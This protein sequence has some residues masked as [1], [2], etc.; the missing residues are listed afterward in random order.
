MLAWA[1]R[2]SAYVEVGLLDILEEDGD[3]MLAG[4]AVVDVAGAVGGQIGLAILILGDFVFA[5]RRGS[6]AGSG[7][8]SSEQRAAHVPLIKPHGILHKKERLL[9]QKRRAQGGGEVEM[10]Q[11]HS[12][13]SDHL[14]GI[15]MQFAGHD[16]DCGLAQMPALHSPT[17]AGCYWLAASVIAGWLA[18][19]LAGWALARRQAAQDELAS[20]TLSRLVASHSRSHFTC[21]HT[22]TKRLYLDTTC[23]P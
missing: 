19:W 3:G 6:V 9:G 17:S 2:R 23:W 12:E 16:A 8:S 7:S 11:E 18:G 1:T 13:H 15:Q 20:R 4:L 10:V 21:T 5:A 14:R 22:P